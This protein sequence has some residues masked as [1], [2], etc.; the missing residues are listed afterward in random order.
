MWRH[1]EPLERKQGHSHELRANSLKV[2]TKKGL[3]FN[4][5]RISCP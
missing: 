4:T 1:E 5:P 3:D 2:K